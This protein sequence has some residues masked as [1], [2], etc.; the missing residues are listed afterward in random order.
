MEAES[1]LSFFNAALDGGYHLE[2]LPL[3]YKFQPPQKIS[4]ALSPSRFALSR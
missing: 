1:H 2:A 4:S 3:P